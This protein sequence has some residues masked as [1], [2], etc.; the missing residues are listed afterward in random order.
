MSKALVS[1]DEVKSAL[2]IDSFRNLSKDK[3]MDFVSLNG[4]IYSWVLHI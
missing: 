2:K 4:S 3:I 1:V